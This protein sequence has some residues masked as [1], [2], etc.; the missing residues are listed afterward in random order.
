MLA[1]FRRFAKSPVATVLIALLLVSFA[2]WGIRDVF[3][4]AGTKDAV[5]TAAGRTV[6][7]AR[8]KSMFD[9]YRQQLQQQNQ[10]QPISVADAVAN[11]LDTRILDEVSTDESLS[12][13]IAKAGVQ[14]SDQLVGD[15]LGKQQRFRDPI[16]GRFDKKA[17]AQFLQQE[18]VS[19]ET[20]EGELRDEAAQQHYITGLVAGAGAPRA[21]AALQAVYLGER[22]AFDYLVIPPTAVGQP[23]KPTDADV[24]KFIDD[25]AARLT[26]PQTRTIS[27]V[28]FS[29]SQLLPGIVADPAK[30]QK[31][32]DFEKDALSSAEKRTVIQIPLKSPDQAATAISRLKKGDSPDAIAKDLGTRA[33]TYPEGPQT[34]IPDR[35]LSNAA[36]AM[37]S[38]EVKGPI[39]GDLGTSVVKVV[40]IVPGHQVT[41]D[42]VRPKIE[43]E[44]KKQAA[45]DKVYEMVQKYE[46]ARNGGAPLPAAAKAVGAPVLPFPAFD[47]K[48]QMLNGQPLPAPQKLVQTAFTLA[49]GADSETLQAAPG[50][51][52]AIHLDKITPPTKLT[53]DEIRVPV[54]RQL[55]GQDLV[56]RLSAKADELAARIRKGEPVAAVASSAGA[57]IGRGVDVTRQMADKSYSAEFL[58]KIFAAKPGDVVSGR[59]IKL[60]YVVGKLTGVAT[61]PVPELAV[62]TEQSRTAVRQALAEDMVAR[63]RTAARDI[64]KPKVDA[65]RARDAI[66]AG[67]PAA[68]Q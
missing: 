12:A 53:I 42:E 48:G 13:Y 52:Y 38:G 24:Q 4:R 60:G 51:Y 62:A 33:V 6:D 65:K 30:V 19:A 9:R 55:V 66:G 28:R 64:I 8:F 27:L 5:V 47:T 25:N 31:R 49:L 61:A 23:I 32:F 63:T 35:Q 10:G 20:V 68:A 36:F 18:Q 54:E 44:V 56:K 21:Y 16:S 45:A 17:Y 43:A 14:P 2:V 15:I 40:S 34:A 26:R 41:L 3:G 11:G 37:A 58:G 39:A 57:S 50:E 67:D 7:S 59:D 1:Q 46:D 29:A 22:R